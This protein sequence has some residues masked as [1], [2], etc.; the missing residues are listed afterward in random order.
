MQ[1]TAGRTVASGRMP[2][3]ARELL[4][5]RRV[6]PDERRREPDDEEHEGGLHAPDASR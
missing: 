1:V 5:V 2:A 3:L 4:Q 6:R